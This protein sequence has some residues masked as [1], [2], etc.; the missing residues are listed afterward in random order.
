MK[1]ILIIASL[2]VMLLTACG[3]R[4]YVYENRGRG[5]NRYGGYA[6]HHDHDRNDGYGYGGY[7]R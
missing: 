2:L 4:T 1:R 6:H 7:R 3:R 5:Y